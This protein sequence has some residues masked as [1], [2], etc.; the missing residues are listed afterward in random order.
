MDRIVIEVADATAKRWW[1]K[2]P[3]ARQNIAQEMDK[4]L[5]IILEKSN[6][7]FWPFMDSIRSKAESKGFNDN[8]LQE[9]LDEK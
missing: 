3:E 6:D 4:L 2:T 9:I 1:Y 8:I 7:E 5:Q